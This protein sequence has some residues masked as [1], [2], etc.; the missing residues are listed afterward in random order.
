[1]CNILKLLALFVCLDV[2]DRFFSA[3][4]ARSGDGEGTSNNSPKF[5]H[6][7]HQKIPFTKFISSS[8]RIV[9]PSP[10]ISFSQ[11]TDL[12]KLLEKMRSWFLVRGY[13]KDLIE[14]EVK[15]VSFKSKNRNTKRGKSLKAVAPVMSYHLKLKSMN[16]VILKSLDLLYMDNE[17][18][19]VPTPKP[20]IS[21][22]RK[23]SSYLA[24]AK[25]Y[26]T[27]NTVGSYKCGEKR[28]EVCINVNETST[29][30]STVTVETYITNH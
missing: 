20:V 2:L 28:Y 11:I 5:T 23:L 21:F 24:K 26:S 17:S 4:C 22:R 27:E 8:I 16:K 30:T 1:M 12:L 6:F 14:S 7:P 18:K 15:K 9:I 19:R 13:T 29:F 3:Q 10:S 25:L